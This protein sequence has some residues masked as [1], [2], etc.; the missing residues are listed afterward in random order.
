MI[1]FPNCKINLGLKILRKRTDGYHDL[2]TLLYPLPIKDVLEITHSDE[3]G[4]IASGIPIPGDPETN[5]CLRAY[6][7]VKK[8]FPALP[9][10][11]IHLHKHIPIGAGLG[12]GSAD[13]AAMLQLLNTGFQ[14]GL[15]VDKLIQYAAELGSDCPFFI[16]NKPCLGGGRGEK[17]RPVQLDMSPYSFV[18]VHPEIHISTAWA[19]SQCMPG[20]EGRTVEEIVQQPVDTWA[21][22]LVN[23]FEVPVF[24]RYPELRSVK[25]R[26][27][28][29]GAIYAALTGSGSGFFG[30]FGK[31]KI[32]SLS[33]EPNF[34][35]LLLT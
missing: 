29:Q 12:G 24:K 35:V 28:E 20:E 22:D 21:G 5:L 17:L 16:L 25:E 32:S 19:F 31:G 6:N 7:L 1:F 10:V 8:D 18:I 2:D 4:F 11:R 23:D 3:P 26:L 13:G 14:L 9:A 27:Y 33:F 34:Q 30:I 15:S